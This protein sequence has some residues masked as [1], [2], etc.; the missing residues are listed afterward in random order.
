[1]YARAKAPIIIKK[2]RPCLNKPKRFPFAIK[3][4][5]ILISR[6]ER[7][8]MNRVESAFNKNP[9]SFS[10]SK[11]PKLIFSLRKKN[12]RTY[13]SATS[14]VNIFEYFDEMLKGLNL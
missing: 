8:K 5:T 9:V 3:E 2:D 7:K 14:K 1:M 13:I 10:P 12:K 6:I 11:K 4:A